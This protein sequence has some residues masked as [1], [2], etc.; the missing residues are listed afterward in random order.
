MRRLPDRMTLEQPRVSPL[1]SRL[2]SWGKSIW[3]QGKGQFRCP[4][5]CPRDFVWVSTEQENGDSECG[6]VAGTKQVGF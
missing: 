2:R 4:D 5:E 3:G 6:E 1:R